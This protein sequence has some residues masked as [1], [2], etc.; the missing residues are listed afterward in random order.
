VSEIPNP[1]DKK[2]GNC[3]DFL[4]TPTSSQTH[5][6][7]SKLV[8]IGLLNKNPCPILEVRKH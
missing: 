1:T 8:L 3:Q 5:M 7:T 4:L 6:H 2:E